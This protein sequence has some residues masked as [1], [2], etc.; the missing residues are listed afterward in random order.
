MANMDGV[1]PQQLVVQVGL[2]IQDQHPAMKHCTNLSWW[3]V[4]WG[5]ATLSL[6]L[7]H[8]PPDTGNVPRQCMNKGLVGQR[9][10]QGVQVD[11]PHPAQAMAFQPAQSL[12]GIEHPLH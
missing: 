12:Q 8:H 7:P 9:G 2:H 11:R 1:S 6:D 4:V 5:H 3:L 10:H